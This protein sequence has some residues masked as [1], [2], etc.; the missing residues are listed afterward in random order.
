MNTRTPTSKK[1]GMINQPSLGEQDQTI[2]TTAKALSIMT[3]LIDEHEIG[4]A[5]V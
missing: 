2:M 4:R 1:R 3:S 5:H